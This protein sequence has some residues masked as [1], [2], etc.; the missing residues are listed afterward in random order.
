MIWF[1]IRLPGRTI[2]DD[3]SDGIITVKKSQLE[4]I[5]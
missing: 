1:L 4:Y 3:G 2:E 5:A